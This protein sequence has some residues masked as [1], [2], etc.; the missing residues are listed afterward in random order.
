MLKMIMEFFNPGRRRQAQ[1]IS[2]SRNR[3]AEVM[4][5]TLDHVKEENIQVS[6]ALHQLVKEMQRRKKGSDNNVHS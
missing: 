1:Q 6:A 5:K 2:E 4:S 3:V